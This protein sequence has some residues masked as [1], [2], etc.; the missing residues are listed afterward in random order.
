MNTFNSTWRVE[1]VTR[2]HGV[3]HVAEILSCIMKIAITPVE[4]SVN[5]DLESLK[6]YNRMKLLFD[7]IEN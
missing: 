4:L 1:G 2:D 5:S 6:T 7:N 3:C